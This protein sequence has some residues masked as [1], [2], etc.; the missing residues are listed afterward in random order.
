MA[1]PSTFHH[2]PALVEL[3]F[4]QA[5]LNAAVAF[6][7]DI[8]PGALAELGGEARPFLRGQPAPALVMRR[9]QPFA[10]YPDKPEI[11]A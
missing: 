7:P 10:L 8:D 11:A 6:V 9:S 5:E 3:L 2:R 4:A 1:P